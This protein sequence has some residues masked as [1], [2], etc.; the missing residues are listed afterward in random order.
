[1]KTLRCGNTSAYYSNGLL[2][3][4][5]MPGTMGGLYRELKRNGLTL[6]DIRFVLATHYH[7]DHMGLIGELNSLGVRLLLLDH[8]TDYVG[9]SDKIFARD[10]RLRPVPIDV[11]KAVVLSC[12]ESRSF[13]KSIGIDGEIVP[14][15]SHSPDGIALVT[16]GGECFVGD[17]EPLS[18]VEACG[19]DSPLA[20]DWETILR[21]H[22]KTAYF[23][24]VNPQILK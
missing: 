13:L 7:P 2:I 18:Y 12:A 11:G 5:D 16:D 19:Q 22:P 24:H 1:M 21:L 9:F 10:P 14:T 23:G 4:T 15:F 6:G 3:D 20:K 17:L 8:Q